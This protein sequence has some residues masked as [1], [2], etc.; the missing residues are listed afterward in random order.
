MTHKADILQIGMP[1]EDVKAIFCRIMNNVEL[2]MKEWNNIS[3]DKRGEIFQGDLS[4]YVTLPHIN[5][6]MRVL[7]ANGAVPLSND[8]MDPL[9]EYMDLVDR[10]IADLEQN[11]RSSLW[12][13]RPRIC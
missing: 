10:V 12:R 5:A 13:I 1:P 7:D 2:G 8:D 4:R 11:W 6:S 9:K 3:A